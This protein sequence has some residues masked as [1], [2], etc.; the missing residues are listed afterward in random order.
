MSRQIDALIIGAERRTKEGRAG[1][2]GFADM[3]ELAQYF[4][5]YTFDKL[6]AGAKKAKVPID[7]ELIRSLN[8]K[9]DLDS[10]GIPKFQ[11]SFNA[12][13]KYIEMKELFYSKYPPIDDLKSWVAKRGVSRFKYVPGY[14]NSGT[15]PSN[16]VAIARIAWGVA[17]ARRYGSVNNQYGKNRRR[18]VWKQK[19]INAAQYHLLHLVQEYM[20]SVA[21][22]ALIENLSVTSR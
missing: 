3:D 20:T 17:T 5:Q 1:G 10:N 6:I 2:A 16:D 18:K 21:Q 7:S 14:E 22:N 4:G 12:Y 11:I 15:R 9:F 8:I 19:Q 13:G